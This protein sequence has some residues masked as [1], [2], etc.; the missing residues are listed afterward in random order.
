MYDKQWDKLVDAAN[1]KAGYEKFKYDDAYDVIYEDYNNAWVFYCA[2]IN[3][4]SA[5]DDFREKYC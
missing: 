4:K 5:K 2:A 3:W 1:A